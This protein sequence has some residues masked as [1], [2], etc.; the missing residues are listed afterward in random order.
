MPS[1]CAPIK[2]LP[3]VVLIAASGKMMPITGKHMPPA[4]NR[5]SANA[6]ISTATALAWLLRLVPANEISKEET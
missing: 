1:N 5:N 2:W 3:T 4:C 6:L